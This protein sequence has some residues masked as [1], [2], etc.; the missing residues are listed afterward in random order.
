[1]LTLLLL[2]CAPDAPP[3]P[4]WS[5]DVR[6]IVHERCAS[7]H[8]TG[9]SGPFPLD[10]Y[11]AMS[12]YA[13][14]ALASMEAGTMPPW[15]ADPSCRHYEG[16]RLLADGELDTVRAWVAAGT[17]QGDIGG[18]APYVAPAS[19]FTPTDRAAVDG[20]LPDA[21]EPDDWRCFLLEDLRSPETR[22]L[23]GTQVV[24]S[25]ALVH[26]VLVYALP[27]A[28]RDALIAADE[29]EAGAGYT[30]FGGPNPA[31]EEGGSDAGSTVA[32][33]FP[34]QIGGWV[35]GATPAVLP[36][37]V[38]I[39]VNADDIIVMQVHYNTLAA[40]P[41]PDTTE[42]E[43]AFG[44]EPTASL[45]TTH[46]LAAP[47]LDIPA[48]DPD[49]TVTASYPN[50]GDPLTLRTVLAHMHLLGV[51]QT[52]A[53]THADGTRTCL[54]DVPEWDF[55]WQQTYVLRAEDDPVIVDV[56]DSLELTCR[57]DN[58]AANQPTVNGAQQA[59]RDVEW[60]ESTLDEMCLAYFT[61]V[62]PFFEAPDASA[63]A[64]AG[65]EACMDAC[66]PE[67]TLDCLLSCPESDFACFRCTFQGAQTC[68]ASTCTGELLAARDCLTTCA[69][70]AVMLDGN[71][72]R[73]L[74]AECPDEYA[75]VQACVDPILASG[76]CDDMLGECGVTV[77]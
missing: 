72:G 10:T 27:A 4:T 16:E 51:Q 44:T 32:D 64:C 54:L 74:A 3:A 21:A 55:D 8:A 40:E 50:Y 53:V 33:G 68:G 9:G 14:A 43:L 76:S 71:V 52:V 46:P 5:A 20:Y 67:P 66:G 59:P 70:A 13:A 37:D 61:E 77:E 2:A 58:S 75:A 35:P 57:Y 30:C 36:D 19:T 41:T 11:A 63:A 6:P 60:G 28:K 42:L 17:P 12:P 23:H 22:Y 38:S 65:T 25:S 1:M 34:N 39:R 31:T 56:G 15:P 69:S 47:D 7:C 24:P 73:C 45:A 29:A 62:Q 26:H 49:V 48:G 18:D